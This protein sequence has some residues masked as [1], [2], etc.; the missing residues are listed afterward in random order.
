VARAD[1]LLHLDLHPRN[2]LLSP[3]G[4]YVID[5]A[6][7]ARG[8]AALDPA[9][10]IAVFVPARA[11]FPGI[12]AAIDRFIAEFASHFDRAELDAAMPLAVELRSRDANVTERERAELAAWRT[13]SAR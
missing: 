4:P 7:A 12:R 1:R 2:V 9:L 13:S 10:A 8:P 6:N 5:W 3:R 11:Q